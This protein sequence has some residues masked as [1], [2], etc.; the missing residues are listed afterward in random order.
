M[1][2]SDLIKAYQDQMI[3]FIDPILFQILL[4]ASQDKLFICEATEKSLIMTTTCISPNLLLKKL[5][6]YVKHKNPRIWAKVS[7]C[8]W[9]SVHR[10]GV[11][12]IK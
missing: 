12:M 4:K 5:E 10:L 6:L 2:S 9:R 3:D 8:I 7:M 1:A 11:D